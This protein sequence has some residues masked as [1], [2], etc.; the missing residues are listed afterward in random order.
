MKLV[1]LGKPG[2]GKGTEAE[3]LARSLRIPS[4]STGDMLRSIEKKKT[5]L[6]GIVRHYIDKGEMLPDGIVVD[7]IKKRISK[8]DCRKGF[9]LDGFPRYIE[10]A[11]ALEKIAK[12]DKA[13]YMDVTDSQIIKR[14]SSR[15]N[16]S[17]GAVY[18][19]ITNPPKNKDI[20]GK[21][22]K[23]LFIRKDDN[24]RIIKNRLRIYNK[25]TKPVILFY[26]NKGILLKIDGRKSIPE[27]HKSALK[28]LGITA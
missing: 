27:V 7:I 22:G 4:I 9:I 1:M 21:C 17:C 6:A 26:K 25:I 14:L 19:I 23:R 10:Q 12:I 28:A 15:R 16:C 3:L 24:P 2:S 18:N 5:K 20:C 13:L 8:P 11:K